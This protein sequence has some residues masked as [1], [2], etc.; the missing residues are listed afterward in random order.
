MPQARFKVKSKYHA[1]P[2]VIHG[3][4]FDST[5]EGRR[6]Q[7]LLLLGHA[8]QIAN[9]ELQ[10]HFELRVDGQRIGRYVADFAYDDVKT[11]AR[12]VED[13]KGVK[14]PVYR[15]KKRLVEALYGIRIQET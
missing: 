6:Y 11:G 14:T 3:R 15:L 7:Q 9:L 4:R 12:V 2:M 13:V 10:P 1:R 5:R 8:G